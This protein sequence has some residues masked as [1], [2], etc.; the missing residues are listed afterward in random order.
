MVENKQRINISL[1]TDCLFIVGHTEI[2]EED[3]RVSDSGDE[4]QSD[5]Q[6]VLRGGVR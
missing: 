6:G 4:L 2:E 3:H 5:I 1:R